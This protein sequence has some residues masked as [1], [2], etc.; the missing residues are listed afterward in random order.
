MIQS[1][2]VDAVV[3]EKTEFIKGFGREGYEKGMDDKGGGGIS[4]LDGD[5]RVVSGPAHAPR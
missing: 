4:H 5:Q 1:S 3:I 2:R